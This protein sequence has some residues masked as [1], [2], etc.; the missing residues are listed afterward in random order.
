MTRF[1]LVGAAAVG[2]T[3]GAP[4]AQSSEH[5]SAAQATKTITPSASLA[6]TTTYSATIGQGATPDGD[7][8][9]T[10]GSTSSDTTG[11]RTETTITITS[12]PLTNMIT[13]RKTTTTVVNGLA[14]ET[15][16]TTNTYPAPAMA[17]PTVSVATRT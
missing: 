11:A 9:S 4:M 17:Q 10:S 7:Q 15:V 14:T 16:T 12:Y 3:T 1:L 2:L 6:T 8:Y 5:S 13:T